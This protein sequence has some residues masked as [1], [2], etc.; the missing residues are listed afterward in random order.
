MDERDRTD[1]ELV[2]L[3]LATGAP[4]YF[5]EL[6]RRHRERVYRCCRAIVRD[7]DVAAD[8]TQETFVR[9][10]QSIGGYHE[11]VLAAWLTTI[12]RNAAINY[13]RGK[14]RGAV[15]LEAVAH[16]LEPEAGAGELDLRLEVDAALATLPAGQQL[17]LKLFF[18]NGLTYGEIASLLGL[19]PGE[20]KSHIQNGKGRIKRA[21]MGR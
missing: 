14:D 10:L 20:V 17:C 13:I 9:A 2:R 18:Y 6:F 8:L 1:Q 11:G 4:E 12:A 16:R 5:A 15:N 19:T 7:A 21:G 3:H